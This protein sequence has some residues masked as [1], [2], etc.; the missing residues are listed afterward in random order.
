MS[1]TAAI[2]RSGGSGK[3]WATSCTHAEGSSG[4]E[5]FL[6][7]PPWA[8]HPATFIPGHF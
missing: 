7:R 1:S 8:G 6:H 4:E 3:P 2:A 5:A